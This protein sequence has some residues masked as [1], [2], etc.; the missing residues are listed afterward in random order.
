MAMGIVDNDDFESELKKL[1]NPPSHVHIPTIVEPTPIK[2]RTPGA[3]GVPDG[4]RKIIGDESIS[5]GRQ[6]AIELAESFG[7]SASSV[8]AYSKGATSTASYDDRPNVGIINGAKERISKKARSR[9]MLSLNHLTSEKMDITNAKD[10][11]SIAKDMSVVIK[12]MEPAPSPNQLN[13][14]AGKPAFIIY[15][16]QIRQENHFSTVVV[17]E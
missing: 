10:L 4:L 8:A 6:Q 16:P 13:G 3:V 5:N 7:I 14:E 1:K 17:K 12:N 15:S 11:S 2:G 9:L